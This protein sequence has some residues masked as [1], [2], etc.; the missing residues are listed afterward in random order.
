MF[1]TFEETGLFVGRINGALYGFVVHVGYFSLVQSVA[2][3]RVVS[4]EIVMLSSVIK[5]GQG[6]LAIV[7]CTWLWF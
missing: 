2:L 4:T 1:R 5:P 7:Q 6:Y 3:V